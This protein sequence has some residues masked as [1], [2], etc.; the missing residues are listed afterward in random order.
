MDN[1]LYYSVLFL[2]SSEKPRDRWAI[3]DLKPKYGAIFANAHLGT[4]KMRLI[5]ADPIR[6]HPHPHPHPLRFECGQPQMYRKQCQI[7]IQLEKDFLRL[8]CKLIT[9]GQI[10]AQNKTIFQA[11]PKLKPKTK[12]NNRIK[13]TQQSRLLE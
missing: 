9:V 1:I 12:R 11:K 5:Y 4:Q 13:H 2:N 10:K 7:K 6:C 8:A 3:R